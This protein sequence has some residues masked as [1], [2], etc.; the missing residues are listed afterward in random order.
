MND[1]RLIIMNIA[2]ANGISPE[3]TQGVL[4]KNLNMSWVARC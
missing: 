4:H 3:K 1:R 2:K